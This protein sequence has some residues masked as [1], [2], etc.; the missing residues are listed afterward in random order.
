MKKAPLALASILI[1]T[2]A[3]G[4]ETVTLPAK[5]S[6][7]AAGRVLRLREVLRI[8]DSGSAFFFKSPENIQPAPDGGFLVVD[9]NE[10]L[11][12]DARGKFIVNMFRAGQGPGEFRRIDDYLIQGLRL[13]AFQANPMK[14]VSMDLDGEFLREVKPEARVS[15]LLGRC[16]DRLLAAEESFPAF[17][18]VRKP[19]GELLDIVWTL[20][21]MNE[22][23]RV[24]ATSLTFPIKWFAMRLGGAFIADHVTFFHCVPLEDGLVAVAH[25]EG[26]AVKIADPRRNAVVR[27]IRRDYRRVKYAPEKD[28]DPPG[29]ARGLAFPLAHFNDIQKVY[30]VEGRIWAVTS[31]LEPA[32]G[33]LVDVISP[34]GEYLDNFYL[35]LPKGV[36]LPRLV[37]HPLTISGRTVLALEYLETGELEVVKYEIVE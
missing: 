3:F 21:L 30:A 27:T 6:N 10:F 33:V 26:Y 22:E 35:P 9:E 12:F 28:A 23:G 16:G 11:T 18:K 5:P 7:P 25:E 31:T 37:R 17:D 29:G 15:R 8:S 34:R 2:A 1:F 36:S 20:K 14:C 13:L 19:E 4:Q 32:K 24:E